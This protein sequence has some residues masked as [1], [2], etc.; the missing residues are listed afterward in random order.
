MQL[1]DATAGQV[2][3]NCRN[4]RFYRYIRAEGQRVRIRPLELFPNGLLQEKTTDTIVESDLEVELVGDWS[5]GLYIESKGG[6]GRVAYER[7][8][9]R[10]VEQEE[11]LLAEAETIDPKERGSHAN[12][13]KSVV[14][15]L[16]VVR[17]GLAE[18][19]EDR[20]LCKVRKDRKGASVVAT[21]MQLP[22]G[23]P[24]RVL[25]VKRDVA[26]IEVKGPSG[27]LNLELS[28]DVLKPWDRTRAT[29]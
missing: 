26:Q 18:P 3:R 12:K 17:Q 28:F 13:V 4:L 2:V 9:A 27:I 10:L 14:D 21:S 15:R 20:K 19:P 22:S 25:G 8:L 6:R 7:E 1:R 29:I 23:L 5:E 24:A 16:K 11:A